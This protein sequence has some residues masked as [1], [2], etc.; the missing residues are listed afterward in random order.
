MLSEPEEAE[1]RGHRYTRTGYV[2]RSSECG[3]M[4]RRPATDRIALRRARPGS[5]L[6]RARR[7]NEKQ[8]YRARARS[9]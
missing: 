4:T 7:E 3:P 5:Y 6:E 9:K 1:R 8:R 2:K